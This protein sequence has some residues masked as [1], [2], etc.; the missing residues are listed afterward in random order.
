MN[1]TDCDVGGR[2]GDAVAIRFTS[3]FVRWMDLRTEHLKR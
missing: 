1:P 3:G 2:G